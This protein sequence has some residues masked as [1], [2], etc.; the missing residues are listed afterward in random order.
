MIDHGGGKGDREWN[1]VK[2]KN[3]NKKPGDWFL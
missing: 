3:K 2:K 1:T